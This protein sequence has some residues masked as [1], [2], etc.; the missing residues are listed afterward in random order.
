MEVSEDVEAGVVER[1]HR[2]KYTD[3]KRPERR[4]ISRKYWISEHCPRDLKNQSRQQDIA[5]KSDR[6]L[7]RAEV[8]R[9]A[10]QCAPFKIDFSADCEYNARTH[11][12]NSETA[13]LHEKQNDRLSE[14]RERIRNIHHD[15]PRDAHRAC[16]R[17]KRIRIAQ[18]NAVPDA[19]RQA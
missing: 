15:K 19:E 3:E 14:Q 4:I 6:S 5:Q 12:R 2:V 17:I 18:R 7:I 9:L 16:C 1:R 11:R 10:Y 8:H 13:D